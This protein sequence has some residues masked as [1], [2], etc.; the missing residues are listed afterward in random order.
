MPLGLFTSQYN[1]DLWLEDG[2][3]VRLENVTVG[4]SF[5]FADS[6]YLDSMRFSF[7][8]NNLL[9]L[10]NYSG[11]DPEVN[12]SGGNGGGG[13]NGFYPRVRS[14]SVGLNVKFK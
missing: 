11:M 6:K 8:G 12:Y 5:E 9:L 13:D 1:S 7:T 14:F 3:F 10:T 2:S 4:Y